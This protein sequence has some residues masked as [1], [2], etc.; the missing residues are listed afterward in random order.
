MCVLWSFFP[1]CQQG[2]NINFIL[3]NT[4]YKV[5]QP[6]LGFLEYQSAGLAGGRGAKNRLADSQGLDGTGLTGRSTNRMGLVLRSIMGRG[7]ATPVP[8]SDLLIP[9]YQPC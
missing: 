9:L 3:T 4:E 1:P 7:I 2:S 8:R 5:P 6:R